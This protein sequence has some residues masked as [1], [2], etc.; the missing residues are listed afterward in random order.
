MLRAA[1]APVVLGLVVAGCGSSGSKS[2]GALKKTSG[3]KQV[4][5]VAVVS[6]SNMID[7]EKLTKNFEA[8]NPNIKVV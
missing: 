6:N 4:V 1:I 3:G 7:I 2:G 5:R 8:Q